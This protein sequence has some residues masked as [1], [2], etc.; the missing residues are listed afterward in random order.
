MIG[1]DIRTRARLEGLPGLAGRIDGVVSGA[2]P[3]D[4]GTYEVVVIDLDETGT[5]PIAELRGSGFAGRI[6]G[7]FSHVDEDLGRRAEQAGIE[8]IRRGRFWREAAEILNR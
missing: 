5:D 3:G 2:L 1:R 4:L 7:F 6:V 8:A